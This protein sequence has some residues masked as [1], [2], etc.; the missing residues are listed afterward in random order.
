MN[1]DIIVPFFFVLSVSFVIGYALKLRYD[2]RELQHKERLAAL[3]KGAQLPA[4]VEDGRWPSASPRI[5]LLRGMM[6]LFSGI[7]LVIF[8][9]G[10]TAASQQPETIENRA[11]TALR[12]SRAW[13]QPPIRFRK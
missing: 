12:I 6:W 9:L 4:L 13:A 10:A 8:L 11:F 5:Y 2:R 7:A 3:E 1:A